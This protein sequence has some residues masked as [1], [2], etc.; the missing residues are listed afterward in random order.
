M[1]DDNRILAEKMIVFNQV[2][3]DKFTKPGY[4]FATIALSI[5]LSETLIML[6]FSYFPS[7][8]L[9]KSALLDA[10]ILS[11]II[12]PMLF[13]LVL[14]PMRT[15]L[16]Q[17]ILLENEREKL[18]IKL[19]VAL[20]EIKVLK[21]LIPICTWCKKIRDDTG[22]WKKIEFYIEERSEAKFTHGICPTCAK[23]EFPNCF[24]NQL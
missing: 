21:G 1:D 7:T 2:S 10:T 6:F 5:F 19:Q 16:N 3:T 15:Y 4:L 8:S 22:Y 24:S 14:R 17:R 12:F 9:L 11:V 18:I 23:K 13:L 20:S